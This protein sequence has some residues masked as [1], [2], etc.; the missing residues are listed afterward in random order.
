MAT[1]RDAKADA[2]KRLRAGLA[3]ARAIYDGPAKTPDDEDR[4][5]AAAVNAIDAVVTFLR[6]N[7]VS[8]KDR[9]PLLD[10]LAAFRDHSRGKPNS[11]FARVKRPGGGT[12]SHTAG[13]RAVVAAAVTLLGR[14]KV[15]K[16]DAL[17]IVANS[18]KK[19]GITDVTKTNVETWHREI[20]NERHA[21]PGAIQIYKSVLAKADETHPGLPGRA[22]ELLLA[23]LPGLSPTQEL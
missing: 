4:G 8:F 22:A 21:D 3:E 12:H 15:K 13:W 23:E 20:S 19:A 9:Q 6:D 5:P 2:M 16:R 10:I 17:K 11:L 18:L 14:D 1:E 7:G